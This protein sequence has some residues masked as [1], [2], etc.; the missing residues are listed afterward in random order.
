MSLI[1][2]QIIVHTL[3]HTAEFC[4][5]FGGPRLWQ[6][7]NSVTEKNYQ[8]GVTTDINQERQINLPTKRKIVNIYLFFPEIPKHYGHLPDI[9]VEIDIT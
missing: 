7:H 8:I 5:K 1:Y 9:C 6:L 4:G 3:L 2:W